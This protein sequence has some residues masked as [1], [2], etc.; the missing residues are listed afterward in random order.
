[1]NIEQQSL[2]LTPDNQEVIQYTMT[3]ASGAS[4]KVINIGAAIASIV[5]PNKD[6]EMTDVVLGYKSYNDYLVDP[7]ALGKSVGRFANRIAKG[8]FTLDG[9]EYTLAINN[10]VNALHG[11]PTGFQ[12]RVWASR[13][14]GDSV[15]FA[16]ESADGEEGYPGAY[17][18]EVAYSWSDDCEISLV[19]TATCDKRTVTNLTN[20]VYFNLN[21]EG[22]GDILDHVMML[23]A[24]KFLPTDDTQIP[25]GEMEAVAGTPM[26]FTSPKAIGADIK[27]EYTPLIIGKGYDHCW[28]IDGWKSGELMEAGEVYSPKSGIKVAVK[29]TQPGIQIYTGNWLSGTGVAKMGKDH[30]DYEGVAMECQNFPDAPNKPSFPS[31]VLSPGETYEQTIKYKFSLV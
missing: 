3:N 29:T 22:S 8:H 12:S 28:V 13:V 9:V 18:C 7:A 5:V 27:A 1:M 2:G 26:D 14:E 16:Y 19:Y 6:G 24:A 31:P 15:V 20:H 25:T 30:A 10:G 4:V 17:K 21:G 11:G 23:N